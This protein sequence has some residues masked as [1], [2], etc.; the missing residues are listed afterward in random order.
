MKKYP[1]SKQW[2]YQHIMVPEDDFGPLWVVEY[3]TGWWIFKWWKRWRTFYS[4]EDARHEY[5]RM[6][7]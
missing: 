6:I 1:T 4:Y 5:L 7:S 3:K 2:R